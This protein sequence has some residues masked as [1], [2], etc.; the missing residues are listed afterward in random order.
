MPTGHNHGID[1]AL[2]AE[3]DAVGLLEGT[4]PGPW[5]ADDF[6]EEILGGVQGELEEL[7]NDE[8]QTT[9]ELGFARLE[10]LILQNG[11][12]PTEVAVRKPERLRSPATKKLR[13]ST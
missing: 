1:D 11:S 9:V 13:R 3:P 2:P 7:L 4:T 8:L 10:K 5:I 6:C 12:P